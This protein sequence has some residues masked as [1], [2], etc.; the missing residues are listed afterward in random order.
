MNLWS[1]GKCFNWIAFFSTSL[2]TC[3]GSSFFFFLPSPEGVRLRNLELTM[4]RTVFI[5]D[6]ITFQRRKKK[7]KWSILTEEKYLN[8]E[9][10]G[11]F[12]L[13]KKKWKSIIKSII[14]CYF[15]CKVG[16]ELTSQSIELM[17]HL[18]NNVKIFNKHH[19]C[20]QDD[21]QTVSVLTDELPFC[22]LTLHSHRTQIEHLER[23]ISTLNQCKDACLEVLRRDRRI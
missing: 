22:R 12:Y 1:H 19:H 5:T 8:K 17:F 10:T 15:L 7:F 6:R 4:F 3:A 11:T 14:T 18:L 20:M 13:V 23:V 21:G 16:Y 2:S 9:G